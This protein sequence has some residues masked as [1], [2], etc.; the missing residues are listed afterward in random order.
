MLNKESYK[1]RGNYNFQ[2]PAPQPP[3]TQV[4]KLQPP[5]P[6][7]STWASPDRSPDGSGRCGPSNLKFCQPGKC[8]NKD[9]YCGT[10]ED[11]CCNNNYTAYNYNGTN[12]P[13]CGSFKQQNKFLKTFGGRKFSKQ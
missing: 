11:H 1:G 5:S 8:C 3:S 6:G 4:V 13:T 2:P 10:S 12:A 7:T 9:G